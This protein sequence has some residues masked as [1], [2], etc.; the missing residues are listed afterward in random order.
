MKEHHNN[1]HSNDRIITIIQQYNLKHYYNLLN[2]NDNM[3][4]IKWIK[5]TP[6]N[7]MMY[8]LVKYLII[9]PNYYV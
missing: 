8:E 4:N 5:S 9:D 7:Y 1:N 6:I 3:N 2:N